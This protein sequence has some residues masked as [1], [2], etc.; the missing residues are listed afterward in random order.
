MQNRDSVMNGQADILKTMSSTFGQKFKLKF[1]D[2]AFLVI[3]WIHGVSM[4]IWKQVVFFDCDI[5][6]RRIIVENG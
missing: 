6:V 4:T 3:G 2:L 1:L 5:L